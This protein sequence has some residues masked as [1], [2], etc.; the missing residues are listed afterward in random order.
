MRFLFIFAGGKPNKKQI[1]ARS[2]ELDTAKLIELEKEGE[3][4]LLQSDKILQQASCAL[5]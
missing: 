5:F 2:K 4:M 1:K 3:C